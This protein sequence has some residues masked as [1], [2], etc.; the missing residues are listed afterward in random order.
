MS[1]LD[2]RRLKSQEAI[3]NSVIELISEKNFDEITIQD[4][5]D[6]ANVSRG[7]IY[8]HYIDK[9]DL[10]EKLIEEHMNEMQEFCESIAELD[11]ID[12][13]QIWFEYI[14]SNYLFFSTMLASKGEPYFHNRFLEF[15]TEE[16]QNEIKVHMGNNRGL[17]KEIILQFLVTSYVGIVE[18][19]VKNEMP[20]PP[21]VMAEQVGILF[22]RN[23]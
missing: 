6:R 2:R 18:W 21:N 9:F 7:T 3:K 11:Y 14:E 22:E 17:N 20:Y 13:N 12:A 23:L 4:I 8:S 19:W 5:S 1:K 10:L 16:F 15:L